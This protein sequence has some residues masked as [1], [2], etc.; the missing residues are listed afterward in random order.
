MY[1]ELF[2]VGDFAVT[3]FGVMMALAFLA[4]YQVIRSE[5]K[6]VGRDPDIAADILLGALIGGIVGAKIYYVL[7]N[8][9]R[10]VVD[11]FGMIFARSGLVWY[12]GFIGGAIGVLYTIRR[13]KLPVRVAMD[14]VAPA[15]ALS[16]AIGRIG[17]FLVG[18]DYG[19]PT[20][21]AVG[22]AFP[23]GLPPTTAGN[24]RRAFGVDIAEG[25]PDG[26]VLAVHPTQ[27]Y[28]VGMSLLIFFI[29][30][31][32]RG[33]RPPGWLFAMW[34]MFAGAER[35]IVEFFRAKDD[36][37]FGVLTLAQVI[38]IGLIVVGAFLAHRFTA[39]P[40]RD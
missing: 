14:A 9:D 15:L 23:N 36:R 19:R 33:S 17:C 11:P 5:L 24:L 39:T 26:Q 35:F 32:L 40:A 37:F 7:L 28:E 16:Y 25:I 21:S 4:G 18:D 22:I 29:L 38:S 30:M 31:K 27:L 34:L 10:T 12:G 2:R 3:S 20:D 1:P 8:W 13:R 6:R